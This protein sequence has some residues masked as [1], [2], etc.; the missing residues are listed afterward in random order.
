V[1]DYLVSVGYSGFAVCEYEKWWHPE[2]PDPME[3]LP[4]ELSYVKALFGGA[5][6]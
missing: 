6:P 1:V 5:R 2:L 4:K 3:A